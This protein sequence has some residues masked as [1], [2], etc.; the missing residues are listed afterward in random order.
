[1]VVRKVPARM[2]S[3]MVFVSLSLS[4]RYLCFGFVVFA[5]EHSDDAGCEDH[6]EEG[7]GY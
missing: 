4:F 5:G 3:C 7:G 1:M 6:G 2:S